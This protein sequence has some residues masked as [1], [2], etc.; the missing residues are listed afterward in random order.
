VFACL[1]VVTACAPAAPSAPAPTSAAASTAVGKPAAAGPA[2]TATS[3]PQTAP[4][5]QTTPA[6]Q[7]TSAAQTTLASQTTPA[8]QAAAAATP[9]APASSAPASVRYGLPTSPPTLDTVGVYFAIDNNFFKDEGLDVQVTP[10]AGGTTAVRALLSREVDVIETD[11]SSAMLANLSGAPTK[12][13]S[14]PY[15]KP[16]D[17]IIAN[18]AVGSISDLQGKS[19]AIS[20]P[21][22]QSHLIAKIVASK[23]GVDPSRID[24]VAVGSPADRGRAVV[25]GRVDATSMVIAI[26]KPIL[27]AVDAGDLKII[28]SIGDQV[29]DLPDGYDVTRDDLIRDHPDVLARFVKAELRGLRWAQQNPEAAA[30]LAEQH[31]PE[32][33]HDLMTRGMQAMLDLGVYGLDGGLTLDQVDKTQK[34]LVDLGVLARPGKPEDL[35]TSQFVDAAVKEL[36]PAQR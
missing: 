16:L 27:D 30:T 24:F 7:S 15:Q 21:N 12:V 33:P 25:G 5:P 34:L 36:G 28:G 23:N 18:K 35:A 32:V 29:P 20:A 8:P 19:W 11:P 10:F 26:S 4:G 13:I 9:T 2:G 14:A 1:L 31:I 3:A 6:S 17:V 22:S